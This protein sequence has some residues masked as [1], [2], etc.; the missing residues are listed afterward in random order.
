[1]GGEGGGAIS[2]SLSGGAKA[3]E[4]FGS[5]GLGR[6]RLGVVTAEDWEVGAVVGAR[7]IAKT[8]TSVLRKGVVKREVEDTGLVAGASPESPDVL[9]FPK[10]GCRM[11]RLGREGDLGREN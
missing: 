4:R 10:C 9:V 6:P 8:I 5:G 2:T 1:M 3:C 7:S 11:L